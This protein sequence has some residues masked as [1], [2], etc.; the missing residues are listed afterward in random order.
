MIAVA[1]KNEIFGQRVKKLRQK[2]NISQERVAKAIGVSRARYSHYENNHVEPDIELIRKMADF[3]DVN[4]DFL[5]GRTDY[6][7]TND[8]IDDEKTAIMNKI[9]N[10]FPDADLMFHDL[11]G[12]SAE[13][14]QEVYEF[15]KFKKSQR[16]ED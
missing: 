14:L 10:D 15:I 2:M 5:I 8:N 13:D 7:E 11:A 1:D 9:A 12:M 16:K 6:P 4:T 3:Y